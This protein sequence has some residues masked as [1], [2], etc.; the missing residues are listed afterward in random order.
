MSCIQMKMLPEEAINA[1]TINGLMPCRYSTNVAALPAAKKPTSFSQ[2][3][4]VNCLSSY[5]FGANLIDKVMING[6]LFHKQSTMPALSTELLLII[7]GSVVVLSYIFSVLSRYIKVPSVLLLL[8]SG[9][10]LRFIANAEHW[11][12]ALP[13]QITEL[14]GVTGLIMIVLEAGLDLRLGKEK[15]SLIR[16]SFFS[17]L[18]VL[19]LSAA[20]VS[21]ALYYWLHEPL[22]NCVVYAIPLSIMSGSIVIPSIHTLT[23][24]KKRISRV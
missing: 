6:L 12:I 22:I 19:L 14:L 10:I 15:V 7:L 2:T 1:A 13:P 9:I 23:E 20:G 8:A 4:P 5:A 21:L 17:A 18:F 11:N 3:D 16:N 24:N